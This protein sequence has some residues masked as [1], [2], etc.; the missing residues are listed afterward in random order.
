MAMIMGKGIE[1]C[2][3]DLAHYSRRLLAKRK[4]K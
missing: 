2:F 3:E 1:S 4:I